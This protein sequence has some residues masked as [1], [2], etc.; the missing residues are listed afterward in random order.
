LNKLTL[1]D[2]CQRID[3]AAEAYYNGTPIVPDSEFDGWIEQLKALDPDNVRLKRVGFKVPENSPLHKVKHR[4]RMGS[5]NNAMNKEEFNAW[6][7]RFKEVTPH[8]RVL[9][10]ITFKMDGASL[11]LYYKNGNLVRA[12][13]RGDGVMGEDVTHNA[14][15][16]QHIPTSV[17]NQ[18]TGS[19]R[20]EVMLYTEDWLTLDPNRESNARNLGNGILRRKNSE[21]ADKLRFIAFCLFDSNGV[22]LGTTETEM[23]NMLTRLGFT[24][25]EGVSNVSAEDVLRFYESILGESENPPVVEGSTF[26]KL[27]RDELP[28][29]IDGLVV[30]AESFE[31]QRLMGESDNR[32][33]GQI[34]FKF[35]PKGEITK[36]VGINVTVGHTGAV[37][38]TAVLEP[39]RVGGV[40]VTAAS[41][42]NWDLV[43]RM[44][45]RI[46][47]TVRVVRAGDVIPKI[48]E[49]VTSNK[50]GALVK[51]PETCPCDRQCKLERKTNI[52][53]SASAALFCTHEDCEFQAVN[54]IK[55][56]LRALDIQGL[57]DVYIDALFEAGVVTTIVDLYTKSSLDLAAVAGLG[58][59]RATKFLQ[60]LQTKGNQLTTSQF[61]GALGIEGLGRRRVLLAQEKS[62]KYYSIE[63]WL[64]G[65]ILEDAAL[66]GLPDTA[67]KVFESIEKNK[68][69]IAALLRH[70]VVVEDPKPEN[71]KNNSKVKTIC[72]TGKLSKP[73]DY[74]YDLIRKAGHLTTDSYSKNVTILVA[75]NINGNSS[76]LKKAR[77]DG[78]EV[79]S[80]ETLLK[81]LE[82]NSL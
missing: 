72:I 80:E 37:V 43:S 45:I 3:E 78:V 18:F 33:K 10:N 52:S 2:L 61:L 17:P 59:L 32:P 65:S 55:K 20:G 4:H 57:G 70:V 19:V 46:G 39:V 35:P 75:A 60:E 66:I 73:K 51:A 22:E 38:P 53:G 1:A 50:E 48:T 12:V 23:R 79:I 25:V 63:E 15:F 36:L 54:K 44:G 16:M 42:S 7:E 82:N 40:T 74:F 6:A 47:D 24:V 77:K 29:E 34:A 8:E 41:L 13:T 27:R 58:A 26:G 76:K 56:W 9:F 49:V 14:V 67:N 69:L 28:F 81:K 62:G 68:G 5:L 11:G 64:S 21:N 71:N 30:K 31:I